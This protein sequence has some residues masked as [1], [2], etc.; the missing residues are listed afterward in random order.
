[1]SATGSF[2][3]DL[4]PQEDIDAPAG[5]MLLRKT[6]EGGMSGSAVGQM[7]SK[8]IDSGTAVYYAVEEFTGT[9]DGRAG[10]FTLLHQGRMS[11][12]GQSL[13]ITIL[14]GSGSGELA[15]ISGSM[16]IT[17]DGTGHRYSLEYEV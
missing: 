12:Q 10:A 1:M 7:I 9:V 2:E 17:Q 16:A 8:R 15:G 14:E 4:T 6:Y 3:V 5:R 11:A 13:K